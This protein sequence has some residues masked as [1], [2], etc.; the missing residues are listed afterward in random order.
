MV[1]AT[2]ISMSS[3]LLFRNYGN[4][5]AYTKFGIAVDA[6]CSILNEIP[7]SI[8]RQKQNKSSNNKTDQKLTDILGLRAQRLCL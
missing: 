2:P 8:L 4:V 5:L 1:T 3:I 7:I 6:I